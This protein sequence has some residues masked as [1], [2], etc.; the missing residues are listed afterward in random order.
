MKVIVDTS[1]WSLALR[2]NT[3]EK[4][5]D[6]S[7][8]HW[9]IIKRIEGRKFY[10]E[11]KV[12]EKHLQT[13]GSFFAFL[14]ESD[15]PG[16]VEKAIQGIGHD[17]Y[18]T[19]IGFPSY[20][21]NCDLSHRPMPPNMMEVYDPMDGI[22]IPQSTF[23]QILLEVGEALLSVK[24]EIGDTSKEWEE[25]MEKVLAALRLKVEQINKDKS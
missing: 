19:G 4:G 17:R 8:I 10:I 20:L 16:I 25:K 18:G 1:V 23:F 21:D 5:E 15:Y 24:K 12:D 9:S 3:Q 14:P 11:L 22:Q 6:M 7:N 13:L 2:H